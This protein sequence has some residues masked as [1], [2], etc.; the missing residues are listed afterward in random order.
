MLISPSVVRSMRFRIAVPSLLIVA[1]VI[2]L[3]AVLLVASVQSHLLSEVDRS[4]VS[5]YHYVRSNI[6]TPQY[7][8]RAGPNGQY[9]EIFAA[10]GR[11][12]GEGANLAGAPPLIHASPVG[13]TPRLM[14]IS[15]AEFG[16][17]RV[18]EV[19]LGD[20]KAPILVV[21]Q[22]INQITDAVNSLKVRLAISSPLLAL[23]VGLLFWLVVGR[24]MRK[25]EAVRTAVGDVSELDLSARVANPRTGDEL[26]RLVVTMNE[27]LTRLQRSVERERQFIADASHELRSP[28]AAARAVLESDGSGSSESH[29]AAL[30]AIQ[31]LQ[32]LAEQLL[33]L[34]RAGRDDRRAEWELVDI[35]EWILAQAE[36]LRVTTSLA[37]D[38]AAVSGGQVMGDESD[39]TRIIENLSS[40]A[41]RYAHSTVAFALEET[42]DWVT[43]RV[44]DDGPGIPDDQK[45]LVFERFR[46]L[47]TDRGR[48][49][50]GSGLGLAIVWELTAKYGGSVRIADNPG[51]GT[52]VGVWLPASTATVRAAELDLPGKY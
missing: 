25:V 3:F 35:D 28:I 51:G 9:G 37:I 31:R 14:T 42:G 21:A 5:E 43:L 19:Q 10:N 29:L 22:A 13:S 39:I 44:S 16:R 27:M 38:T 41:I 40:N 33:V 52:C 49:R 4:L 20:R 34:E 47:D 1:A 8:P 6:S 7:L 46:R 23:A 36:Q 24:A 11:L 17:L 30:Q 2:A 45:Q 18:L 32:Y 12:L 15:S 26:E 48:A 50:G